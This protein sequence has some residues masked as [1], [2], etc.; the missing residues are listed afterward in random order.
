MA[1]PLPLWKLAQQ[2]TLADNFFMGAFGG[3]FLNHFWLICACT[4]V[5][6]HAP[7]TLVAVLDA[8][9][10]LA[11]KPDSPASALNG[12]PQ[13]VNDGAV[14]PDGFAVNT[15]QPPFEPSNIPPA[16]G[17]DP[18]FADPKRNPLPPQTLRTIGDALSAK[19]IDWAWYAEAWNDALADGMQPA[20]RAAKDHRQRRL[21][22]RRISRPIINRST[23]S[24]NMRPEP[25]SAPQH[26]KDY[27]DLVAQIQTNTLPAVASTSRRAVTMSIPATPMCWPVISTLPIWSARYRPARRGHRR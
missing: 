11:L 18:R 22:V 19:G 5:F 25:R 2:Y 4:P 26:L 17:G 21:P 7:S 3:S 27:T 15:M 13:Y 10:N 6:P 24:A 23:T 20:R 16:A 8:N 1:P 14:T 12:P 9:G